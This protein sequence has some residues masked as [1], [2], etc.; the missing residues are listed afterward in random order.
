VKS[1]KRFHDLVI[2]D[3][4]ASARLIVLAGPNGTGK[5]S[6][7]DALRLGITCMEGTALVYLRNITSRLVN[8]PWTGDR[9]CKSTSTNLCQA[10]EMKAE[11][12]FTSGRLT[13][14]RPIFLFP[15]F[16]KWVRL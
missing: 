2:S 5:S 6:L 3:L 13:E 7:F 1:F 14:T 8:L 15:L 10:V 16:R 12:S 11:S 9:L 4:P